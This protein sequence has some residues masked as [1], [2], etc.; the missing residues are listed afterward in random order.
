MNY[1]KKIYILSNIICSERDKKLENV[2]NLKKKILHQHST[3]HYV[4]F[5]INYDI[6]YLSN[7]TCFII[8]VTNY[9]GNN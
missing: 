2:F 9:G 4:E 7:R 3:R 5:N 6:L 1:L 8:F